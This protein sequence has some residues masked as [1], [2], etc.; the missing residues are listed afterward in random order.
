[1]KEDSRLRYRKNPRN[2]G[3]AGNWNAITDNARGDFIVIIGDDDRLLPDFVTRTV[4]AM[5]AGISL[6]FTNHFV[7]DEGGNRLEEETERFTL[8]YG[9][10]ELHAGI[11][12]S[13]EK[14]AWRNAIPMSATL[15]RTADVRR[16]RFKEDLNNPELEFF[17]RLACEGAA[18]IFVPE[19]L[20]EYR[21]HSNS[22]TSVAG[23]RSSR[24][25]DY[26][27]DIPAGPE[28]E[29]V[30]ARYLESIM[31]NAVSQCL[32]AGNRNQAKRFLNSLYYP[33]AKRVGIAGRLQA[34]CA[35]VPRIGPLVYRT[36]A[37]IRRSFRNSSK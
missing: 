3:L 14:C 17:V 13:S 5:K 31:V 10:S 29:P 4:E 18:F 15:M 7:I 35:C 34:T 27:I 12:S 19:Y 26:L 32:I 6:V 21:V 9:R 11:V 28:A 36:V 30:K 24:L 2:L 20:V 16:L 22:E 8:E 37:H 25:M 33:V 1:M 23:L